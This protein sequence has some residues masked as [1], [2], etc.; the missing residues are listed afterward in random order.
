VSATVLLVHHDPFESA[1]IAGVLRARGI[2]STGP[3]ADTSVAL[4][5]ISENVVGAVILGTRDHWERHADIIAASNHAG[6][7]V[8]LLLSK[9][10]SDLPAHL[11]VLMRPF[12]G[13]QVA[14]WASQALAAALR[15]AKDRA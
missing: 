14:D 6:I 12:A 9:P 7:A 10:A 11:S 8:L 1:Y 3:L 5:M 13:F 2:N 15:V 4:A